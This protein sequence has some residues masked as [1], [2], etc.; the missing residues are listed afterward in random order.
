MYVCMYTHSQT[1][2]ERETHLVYIRTYVHTYC[3]YLGS[4]VRTY[5][6]VRIVH[7]VHALSLTQVVSASPS[8]SITAEYE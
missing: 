2:R 1:N 4:Y 7:T 8:D 6:H 5:E 3:T